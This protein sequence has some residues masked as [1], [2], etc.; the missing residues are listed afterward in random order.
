MYIV[1]KKNKTKKHI[2]FKQ[3]ILLGVFSLVFIR[4]ISGGVLPLVGQKVACKNFP[5]ILG[6]CCWLCQSLLVKMLY[7]RNLK[8]RFSSSGTTGSYIG[9]PSPTYSYS[10]F[11]KKYFHIL[12]SA[13]ICTS[14]TYPT[15]GYWF[16]SCDGLICLLCSWSKSPQRTSWLQQL[17]RSGSKEFISLL[18]CRCPHSVQKGRGKRTTWSGLGDYLKSHRADGTRL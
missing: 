18:H 6:C 11:S 16:Y 4:I 3:I 5:L 15:V 7:N 17:R 13:W 8:W 14:P 12:T 9:N 2:V 10:S 1:G